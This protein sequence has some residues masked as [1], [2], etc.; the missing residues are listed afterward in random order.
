MADLQA[1]KSS[2]MD[3]KIESKNES[4]SFAHRLDRFYETLPKNE[5]LL[6]ANVIYNLTDP[7]ERMKWRS[8]NS[9]LEPNEIKILENLESE[10][11]RK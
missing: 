6:L 4:S 5:R 8:L 11:A 7:I 2:D 9:I 10:W 3:D 1:K